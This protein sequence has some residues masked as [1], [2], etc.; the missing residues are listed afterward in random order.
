MFL[1][2]SKIG[3]SDRPQTSKP[4][5]LVDSSGILQPKNSILGV[6]A[7]R[8]CVSRRL[9]SGRDVNEN[10]EQPRGFAGKIL[11]E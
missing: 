3:R 2:Q 9:E 6:M 1:S 10:E 11:K 7:S 8:E 5:F 4:A